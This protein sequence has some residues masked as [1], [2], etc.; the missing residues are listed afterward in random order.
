MT[1]EPSDVSKPPD[2]T[3]EASYKT[4]SWIARGGSDL[5]C[6]IGDS[7]Q[8]THSHNLKPDPISAPPGNEKMVAIEDSDDLQTFP[9]YEANRLGQP[10]GINECVAIFSTKKEFYNHKVKVHTLRLFCSCTVCCGYSQ[11]VG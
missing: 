11:E 7:N 10:C 5:D 2:V 9:T 4:P 3:A 1:W 8:R 6:I